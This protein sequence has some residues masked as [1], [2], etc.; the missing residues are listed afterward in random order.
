MLDIRRYY[1]VHHGRKYANEHAWNNY[2]IRKQRDDL[3]ASGWDDFESYRL[4][5]RA[6]QLS[7]KVSC[8]LLGS[9]R[10]VV[11]SQKRT[12]ITRRNSP[13]FE[14]ARVLARFDH[15]ARYIVNANHGI[16]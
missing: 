1:S 3:P 13:L 2:H 10:R 6:H 11:G 5:I 9:E 12:P 16:T 4:Q 8:L 15:V 7:G 14:I